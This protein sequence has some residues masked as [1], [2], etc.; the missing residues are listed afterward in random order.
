M[1]KMNKFEKKE[2]K[3]KLLILFISCSFVFLSFS[4][5]FAQTQKKN[6]DEIRG[7]KAGRLQTGARP[8][9]R[10]PMPPVP[11]NIPRKPTVAP[12]IIL[13][14]KT[15][16]PLSFILPTD[17]SPANLAV[18]AW[19]AILNGNAKTEIKMKSNIFANPIA[20]IESIPSRDTITISTKAVT[21][22]NN[23]SV[24]AGQESVKILR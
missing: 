7:V 12:R 2:N 16:P 1:N 23:C 17:P 10:P 18:K 22:N 20:A 4:L 5:V 14:N 11:P 6:F 9:F 24:T 3:N 19:A 15:L 21:V 8:G 13:I